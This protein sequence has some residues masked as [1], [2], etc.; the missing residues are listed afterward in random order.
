MSTV[1]DVGPEVRDCIETCSE[2]HDVCATTLAHS[3]RSGGELFESEHLARLVDCVDLCQTTHKLMLR[4]SAI[5]TRACALCAE[6]CTACAES[7]ER[8]AAND[9]QVQR[10]VDMCRR[11]A[12]T[13]SAMA[14]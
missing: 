10:C 2:C 1:T 14:A 11:C 13:C 9:E 6:A 5:H 8:L 3:I 12:S 4:K 7:C